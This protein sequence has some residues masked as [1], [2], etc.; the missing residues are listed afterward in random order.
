MNGKTYTTIQGDMWDSIAHNQLGDVAHT[1]KL[2]NLNR[3][4]RR[5]YIFPAGIELILPEIRPGSP[6]NAPPWRM[7]HE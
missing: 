2:I 1:D 7:L 4:Y 5:I 6:G 3:Q